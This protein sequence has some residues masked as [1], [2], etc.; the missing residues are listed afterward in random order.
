MTGVLS[1]NSNVL[2]LRVQRGLNDST[3]RLSSSFERLSS[4]Q[5][6]NRA[7]DDAAGLAVADQLRV[8]SRLSSGA[9]RNISD[10]VSALNIVDSSLQ[11]QNNLIGRL[12]ELATQA[13][14]GT[15]SDRQRSTLNSEYQKLV[16]EFGR[17][18]STTQFNNINLSLGG[19]DSNLSR[20][21][22]QAGISGSSTSS[23]GFTLSD[24]GTLSGRCNY[25]VGIGALDAPGAIYHGTDA[26]NNAWHGSLVRTS[27]T[28]SNG[29]V[30]EAMITLGATNTFGTGTIQ[31]NIYI[32]GNETDGSFSSDPNDWV[33]VGS[34]SSLFNLANG[35]ASAALSGAG[36]NLAGGATIA[37]NIDVSGLQFSLGTTSTPQ[38]ISSIDF[39]GVETRLIALEALGYL[40]TRRDELSTILG[41][42]GA[43]QSRLKSA[44]AVVATTKENTAAAES[45]IR[46]VDVADESAN[47]IANQIRQQTAA[48]VLG[49][50]NS[51]PKIIL[52]LL[53]NA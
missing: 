16:Q 17:I 28:D 42:V 14:N 47:L 49:L 27:L 32:R 1:L 24:T 33:C 35:K 40:Q 29:V 51:Q 20:L 21:N 18:G 22:I 37:L 7:S 48:Q 50:A 3:S 36:G 6:I 41:N 13:A 43:M 45:R 5:R 44:N 46:D 25:I 23:L 31:S 26:V 15:L 52:S 11:S 39:T 38:N 34:A 9:M 30:H 2:S 12:Q 4:G 8:Q 19:H 53:S 10:A